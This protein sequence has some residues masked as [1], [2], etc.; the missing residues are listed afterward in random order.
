MM[1]GG[2]Q[3]MHKHLPRSA[4]TL[5]GLSSKQQKTSLLQDEPPSLAGDKAS[6]FFLMQHCDQ[7]CMTAPLGR[8]LLYA[9]LDAI[10][11]GSHHPPNVTAPQILRKKCVPS[12]S[13]W[14]ESCR[15]C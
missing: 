12:L 1:L 6:F 2:Q 5:A 8:W 10:P 14:L 7:P 11:L 3:C 13:I 15:P 9:G 4:A